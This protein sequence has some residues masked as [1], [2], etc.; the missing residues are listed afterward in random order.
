MHLL[1][2]LFSLLPM[3]DFGVMFS[4]N[5]A[6]LL[7]LCRGLGLRPT[8]PPLDRFFF[9]SCKST[10][11]ERE[12]RGESDQ[13]FVI[14]RKNESKYSLE[15]AVADPDLELRGGG[16]F[17]ACIAGFSSFCDPFLPEKRRLLPRSASEQC[18]Y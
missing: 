1:L 9:L 6:P 12:A 7:S 2:V 3:S 4:L 5:N 18:V 14:K 17:V 10:S 11:V 13:R 15:T 8:L 16:G